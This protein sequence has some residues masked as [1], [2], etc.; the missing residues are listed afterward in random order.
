MKAFKQ[1][2]SLLLVLAMLISLLPLPVVGDVI[3][4][5]AYADSVI[6]TANLDLWLKADAGVTADANGK[7]SQWADQS[8]KGNHVTQATATKYPSLVTDAVYGKPAI[9]FTGDVGGSS[10]QF[11]SKDLVADSKAWTGNSTVIMVMQQTSLA[12]LNAKG[13]FSNDLGSNIGAWSIVTSTGNPQRL[14]VLGPKE[15]A[16]APGVV[17]GTSNANLEAA[18]TSTPTIMTVTIDTTSDATLGIISAY[19]NG[20]LSSMNGTSVGQVKNAFYKKF[21]NFK[22][23]VIGKSYS[24]SELNMAADV[25]E[26]LVYKGVLSDSDRQTV[27]TYLMNKYFTVSPVVASVP[28]GSITAG[29]A[30][31]LSTPTVGSTVYY[32]LDSSDPLTSGTRLT[33]SA[34]IVISSSTTITAAAKGVGLTDSPV[35]TFTYTLSS[36]LVKPTAS[37]PTGNVAF[38]KTV[39][40]TASAGTTIRYTLDGTD[41][42]TSPSSKDYTA[43]FAIVA[44]TTLRAYAT[45][46]DMTDS[47]ES[48]Y[49]YTLTLADPVKANAISGAIFNGGK[50]KLSSTIEGAS[51][52]YTK[53]GSDPVS[54]G[55]KTLYTTPIVITGATTVKAYAE[56][57]GSAGNAVAQYDYTIYTP[58]SSVTNLPDS[59]YNRDGL[60][61]MPHLNYEAMKV[62]NVKDFGAVGNGD[63]S[64]AEAFDKAINALNSVDGGVVYVPKGFYYFPFDLTD[65]LNRWAW[66][67]N[68]NNVHFI[69]EGD[70]SVIR[71]KLPGIPTLPA[72]RTWTNRNGVF[73]GFAYGWRIDGKDISYKDLAFSWYPRYDARGGAGGYTVATSGENIQMNRVSIDQGNIGAVFWQNTK[74]VYVVDTQVRN[75]AADSIHFANVADVVAA[76]NLVDGA[77]DDSIASIDDKEYNVADNHQYL[78]NTILNSYWGRGITVTGT[79]S[80]V[81]DNWLENIKSSGVYTNNGGQSSVSGNGHDTEH[82]L[83]KNNTIVRSGLMGL[84]DNQKGAIAF[85]QYKDDLTVEN[86]HVYGGQS[87]GIYF[88]PWGPASTIS[89]VRIKNNEIAA[90]AGSAIVFNSNIKVNNIDITNNDMFGNGTAGGSVNFNA[91]ELSGNVNLSNNKVSGAVSNTTYAY[92]FPIVATQ[93]VYTNP[94]AAIAAEPSATDWAGAPVVTVAANEINVKNYGAKGDGATNDTQAFY[95]ALNAIPASGGTLRIPAGTYVLTPLSGKDSRPYSQIKHHLLLE[96]R[97]NVHI[98]GDGDSSVLRFT[99]ADHYGIRLLNLTDSSI[100]NIKLELANKP[101]LRH[102]RSLLDITGSHGVV[103]EHVTVVNSGGSGIQVDAST[104]VSIQACT[105][106]DSN[107][108][109]I[110]LVASRQVYVE[111]STLNGNRDHAIFV[112]KQGSIARLS[113]YIRIAGNVID[114]EGK[115][116]QS[117]IA[118]ASGDNMLALSNTIKN[119]HMAGILFYYTSEVYPTDRITVTGNTLINTNT[120]TNTLTYGAI[121]S[122]MSKGGNF[123]ITENTIQSTPYSGIWV[124]DSTLKSLKLTANSFTDTAT[125]GGAIIDIASD[126]LAAIPQYTANTDQIAVQ[127]KPVRIASGSGWGI[128]VTIQNLMSLQ[129]SAGG[130]VKVMSPTEWA[131]TIAP[132]T[133]STIAPGQSKTVIVPVPAPLPINIGAIPFTIKIDQGDTISNVTKSVNFLASSEAL[134]APVIDGTASEWADTDSAVLNQAS[135]VRFTSSDWTGA[136]DLSATG[137]VKHDETNLYFSVVVKDNVHAQTNTGSDIWRGDSLQ[138][139]IDAGR[140]VSSGQ[141]GNMSEL[142]FA[143]TAGNQPAKWRT[144]APNGKSTGNQFSGELAVQR[145]ETNKTTTYE[146]SLPW[147]EIL[148]NALTDVPERI[149]F[150]FLVND[151]DGTGRRGWIEYMSGIGTSKN[152]SLYGDLLLDQTQPNVAVTGVELDKDTIQIDLASSQKSQKLTASVLP[153]I[154]TNQAVTW[155]S[156]NTPVATVD[157]DGKVTAHSVGTAVITVTTADGGFTATSIVTVSDST[158]TTNNSTSPTTMP[159]GNQ[160]KVETTGSGVVLQPDAAS[161]V[162]NSIDGNNITSLKV[163]ED[164]INKAL[165]ALEDK[166]KGN[167]TIVIK[168]SANTGLQIE[169]SGKSASALVKEK[170]AVLSLLVGKNAIH[171]PVS[172]LDF[173]QIA[174]EWK[175]KQDDL[176]VRIVVLP[177]SKEDKKQVSLLTAST[178]TSLATDVFSFGILVEAG[179]RQQQI[180]S[181]GG[182]YLTQSMSFPAVSNFNKI[183]GV[184]IDSVTGEMVFA[185]TTFALVDGQTVAT[186]RSNGSGIFAIVQSDKNFNDMSGHWAENDVHMLASKLLIK[187]MTTDGFEPEA[188]VTRAQFAVMLSRS[189]GITQKDGALQEFKDVHETDWFNRQLSAALQAGLIDGYED[190]TMK[191]NETISR[192]QMAVMIARALHFTHN[193]IQ[194]TETKEKQIKAGFGDGAS[195]EDWAL[196]AIAKCLEAGILQGV[197][198]NSFGVDQ[199]ATRAQAA[200]TLSRLLKFTKFIN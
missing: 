131:T 18:S 122:M 20:V 67:R 92:G 38:G 86:N 64:D 40:L 113:E 56:L 172:L 33:Y 66:K 32:T 119:T 157:G 54:S 110:L 146:I 142:I 48:V 144:T 124:K 149:G 57:N 68:Y 143:L 29:Q 88:N 193:D 41:P 85:N 98:V 176:K 137:Y 195:I 138:L 159:S 61:N 8:G 53:D 44:T 189:L 24:T 100:R 3:T 179:G 128:A 114:G 101:F 13:I 99:S 1:K 116:E 89:N 11:L 145:N 36:K 59:Y 12:Q 139:G 46:A 192:E 115:S 52:Y 136:D 2:C 132:V 90:V 104:G 22:H 174:Q 162:T 183:T 169:I 106:T 80:R 10:N 74:N 180:D 148:P 69:G 166:G 51:I 121:S 60:E 5:P 170:D 82:L 198:E 76:Y 14:M 147:T 6:P 81:E 72:G 152:P 117:G 125:K 65:P 7:V 93:P 196:E 91:A 187:G 182:T 39:T 95:D 9:R 112:N 155:T 62:A 108:S 151:D 102:N 27:E 188:A 168:E 127:T 47:D 158:T 175:V 107:M 171:V 160:D 83:I 15:K 130:T 96:G 84:N 194:V 70:E 55:T 4:T 35:S 58:T 186:M 181:Y 28:S 50:I 111:N 178:G 200:V 45:K 73:S 23:Y 63:A 126:Q 19:K 26:V 167:K 42:K 163:N 161:R 97:D 87:Y 31:T 30:V 75:T 17:D 153:T 123:T 78:H 185:P 79:N 190:G 150:S 133:F 118:F 25:S 141:A 173:E 134:T 129:P 156:S 94:Y 109:G 140:A 77:N 199:N 177:A 16:D 135:Q 154:A 34:P 49:T 184:M 103:A 71:F 21:N 120:G 105:V 164:L 37:V 165:D 43:P 191:P 197:S